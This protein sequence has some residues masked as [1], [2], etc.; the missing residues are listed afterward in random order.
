MKE[1][2]DRVRN[3]LVA[4]GARNIEVAQVEGE[5][6]MRV[7][8]LFSRGA[9]Q[10]NFWFYMPGAQVRAMEPSDIAAE[11]MSALRQEANIVFDRLGVR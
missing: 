2:I 9:M 4:L 1:K 10:S 6:T 7:K 5:D 3:A 8:V 11:V